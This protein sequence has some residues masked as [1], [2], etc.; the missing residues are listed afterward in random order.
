MNEMLN[1]YGSTPNVRKNMDY[2]D[3]LSILLNG[4]ILTKN[5]PILKVKLG[6]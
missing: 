2:L 4:G 6:I 5:G 1:Y 3:N